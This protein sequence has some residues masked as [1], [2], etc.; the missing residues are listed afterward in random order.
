MLGATQAPAIVIGLDCITGL[1]TAR[2]L[3][4]RGVPVIALA[5]DRGHYACRTRVCQRLIAAETQGEGLVQALTA[6]G[7]TL[8]EKGV[9]FPCTDLSVLA[10]SRHRGA[11]AGWF[12]VALPAPAVVEMLADKLAFHAYAEERGFPVPR[13]L[14]LRSR[15]EAEQ[16]AEELLFPA[17]LKP[18]LK[19]PTWERNTK[20]KAF[21]VSGSE[22]LLTLYDRTASWTDTLVAQEWIPGDDA[23]LFSCNCSF[24]AGGAPLVTFVAR[25]IRQWPP[26]TGTSTLGE[27]CHNDIVLAE[28]VRLFSDVRLRGLGYLEMKR[29]ERT[30]RHVI[31]EP[32]VGR[33]TGRSAIAEAGG[34]ELLYA[35]YC[36]ALGL[37]LPDGLEQRYVGAKWIDDR[38]DLQSA[39][40]YWR[41]RE[42]TL[43]GWRESVRGRK[44][45]A[46]VS[47]HDPAPF[48]AEL[49]QAAAKA[50]RRLLRLPRRA[51]ASAPAGGTALAR[52]GAA[53]VL[54]LAVLAATAAIASGATVKMSY[55]PTA[56]TYV[57]S[58][59]P[60]TE[61]GTS[62]TLA[63]DGKPPTQVFLR[64][65]VSGVGGRPVLGA[66][67]RLYQRDSSDIGG[68]VNSITDTSW[69]EAL[70][71]NTRPPIDGPV[72]GGVGPV[73]AEA[74]YD[75]D[76]GTAVTGDGPVAFAIDSTSSDNA[77]WSSREST[78]AVPRLILDVESQ[79]EVLDGLLQATGSTVG[80][81][82]P[83]YYP[84]N[85]RLAMTAAGRLL[86]IHGRHASGVQLTWRDQAGN[87]Q[88]ETTGAVPDGL[89]IAGT[90]TGDW[91]GS[92]AIARDSTGA[93]HAWVV[94][95]AASY[96]KL[97]PVYMRRLSDLDA[98][99]GPTV[100]PL[101]MIDSGLMG[102]Y[103]PD[104]GFERGADGAVRGTVH[105]SRRTA[106]GVYENV[107]AWFTDLD[108][109]VPTIHDE[110]LIGT[111]SGIRGTFVDSDGMRL[112]A[113][114]PGGKLTMYTHALGA[115]LN[116][117]TAGP[118]GE[119]AAGYPSAVQ[120]DSGEVVAAVESDLTNNVVKVQRFSS[121]GVPLPV[122]LTL[123][124]YSTPSIASDG[125]ALWLVMVRESDG[126]VVSRQFIPELGW[127]ELDTV[128]IGAE[129]G[130]GHRDPNVLR[131]IDGRLRFVVRGPGGTAS[132]ARAA[133][134][135]Y[136][137]PLAPANPTP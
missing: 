129:G 70:T 58:T 125:R 57:N 126:Y 7:P 115:P 83:V 52:M 18:P 78:V 27:E 89:L 105:W 31:I 137:R 47:R 80:S 61:Y 94:W 84:L 132:T 5:R 39:L 133:V 72:V 43:A 124:G 134:L 93:E 86:A 107:I 82:D 119:L 79:G 103:Q 130:G 122:E 10:V 106:L 108:T 100:G 95:S 76:L 19:S 29:D 59:A 68:R 51:A 34:V 45:H 102:A 6:L 109:D 73:T 11:L 110:G 12:H 77:K 135:S 46:V 36:D 8:P 112:L 38:R 35:T 99:D 53:A 63:V 2:I 97:R 14:R 42:L 60:D 120:L 16:A 90:G 13:T 121:A 85:H 92:I 128:E 101:L 75:I 33:P 22:E 69:P 67:L 65:D 64:F 113:R 23:S 20:A 9:L 123:T 98:P 111:S 37:P 3:A 104:I 50:V 117:W 118:R 48:A 44:A 15:A 30:G 127:T 49:R 25:K 131:R 24:G 17:I 26:H 74:Y 116:E 81:S 40:Y 62:S 28:T 41:R 88:T 56:D 91:P 32:N 55:E 136:Q 114:G 1:Q 4:G 66:R 87:W 96:S 21:T 54:A 71:W